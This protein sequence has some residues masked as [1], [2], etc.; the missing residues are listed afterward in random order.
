MAQKFCIARTGWESSCI[1]SLLE[2]CRHSLK[3][4]P[5]HDARGI[6]FAAPISAIHAVIRFQHLRGPP[7]HVQTA[8]LISV[9]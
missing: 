4:R 1:H 3:R 6:V 5:L 2:S 9:S 7:A 8:S